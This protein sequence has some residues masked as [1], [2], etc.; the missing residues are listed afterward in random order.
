MSNSLRRDFLVWKRDL[1]ME[2]FFRFFREEDD[3]E[4]LKWVVFEKFLIFDCLRKGIF[5]V[6]YGIN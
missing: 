4:V 2:I 1:G 3:E 5:I 6:F